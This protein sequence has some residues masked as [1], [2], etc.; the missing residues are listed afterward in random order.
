MSSATSFFGLTEISNKSA[1]GWCNH[2]IKAAR[3]EMKESVRKYK[4]RQS[5]ANLRKLVEVEENDQTAISE[6]KIKQCKSNT[7]F[8]HESKAQL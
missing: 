8:L 5:L 2:N 4:L 7:K 6:A 3:K 1:K